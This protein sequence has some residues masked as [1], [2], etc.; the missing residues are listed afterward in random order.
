MCVSLAPLDGVCLCSPMLANTYVLC[1]NQVLTL[2]NV[3]STSL[4][5]KA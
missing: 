1:K 2:L 3:L 5:Q 4:L